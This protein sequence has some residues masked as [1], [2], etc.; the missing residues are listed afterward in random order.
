MNGHRW[1]SIAL[2]A[3]GLVLVLILHGAIPFVAVPTLGQAVWATGFSQSFVN[4]S[5]MSIHATNFGLPEPAV[6]SFGLA[7]I[8]PVGLLI[9]AGLHPS[10]AYSVMVAAWIGLAFYGAWRIGLSFGLSIPLAM[11]GAV[12]WL[13]MPIIWTH[14]Y[15]S[16]LSLG[17]ALLPFYFWC[18]LR[19]Y[20]HSTEASRERTKLAARY[21]GACVLAVFMD[22]YTFMMFAVGSSILVGYIY[23]HFAERRSYLLR[24]SL[25]LHVS[26]F[27]LAYALYTLYVGRLQFDPSAL[28]FFRS[29]GVD[30]SFIAIPTRGVFWVWDTLG[31]SIPRSDI[32][33]FGD[34][35]VW[36]TTFSLPLIIFGLVAWWKTKSQVQLASAFL[37]LALFGFY[38]ALGPSLK[39][40]SIKTEAMQNSAPGQLSAVVMPAELTVA[41]TGN[42]WIYKYVPGF[43]NMRA[44]YRWSALGVFGFWVLLLLL[45]ANARGG[46]KAFVVAMMGFILFSN[47][48]H[49]DKKWVAD[50]ANRDMFKRIDTDLV[51]DMKDVLRKG[52]LVAFLPWGNDFLVNYLASRASIRTYNIGGDK[53]LVIA[54][55]HWPSAMRLYGMN[56][57]DPDLAE[58]VLLMLSSRKADVV[59]LPYFDLLWS[60]YSWPGPHKHKKNLVPVI[61]TLRASGYVSVEQRENYALVRLVSNKRPDFTYPIIIS[62]RSPSLLRALSQGWHDLESEH[63]WSKQRAE[64]E[65]PIP[66]SCSPGEC[67]AVL[68]FNVFGASE[69]RPVRVIFKLGE[70]EPQIA[71]ELNTRSGAIQR[72][73]IPLPVGSSSSNTLEIEIPDAVSPHALQGSPDRRVLGIALRAVELRRENELAPK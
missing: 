28:E 51:A 45:L 34:G 39:V 60:A 11:L 27:V 49:V 59:V 69:E 32:T 50:R 1:K 58:L 12:L 61:D 73:N 41:P 23:F 65:L 42:A 30:L 67:S 48:P 7:G 21:L 9:S 24:F 25:P 15:Y 46:G 36:I 29:F 31:L 70:G 17:V 56:R 18:A 35:S 8:Y 64:L 5:I 20:E 63:V 53:N 52:E 3:L 2:F 62:E 19:L 44:A 54:S 14:A 37:I 71:P 26:G 40:N 22:G 43:R 13:G 6:P 16:M 68:K 33:H 57:I 55:Q 4:D 10:D 47:L 38:M 66:E 72:V